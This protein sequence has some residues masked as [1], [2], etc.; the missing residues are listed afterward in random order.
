MTTKIGAEATAIERR[1]VKAALAIAAEMGWEQ[2]RLH[3]IADR[4]EL[5]LLEIGQHFRDVDAVANAWYREA[6]EAM[7]AVPRQRVREAAGGRAG[8]AGVRSL[9]RP[10]R[11]ASRDRGR[12]PSPQALPIAPAPLGAAG[13]RPVAAGARSPRRRPGRGLRSPASGA[14]DRPHPDRAGDARRLAPGRK[15]RPAAEQATASSGAWPARA[16]WHG[17][18]G[19]RPLRHRPVAAVDP[20]V[21]PLHAPWRG[22]GPR[23]G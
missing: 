7:L 1:V 2:V 19:V 13:L 18:S 6:R 22:Q 21:G 8:R 11:P 12:D 4:T 20:T 16:V 17:S 15:Q 10:S 14:G 3:A 9:A 23:G 5:A